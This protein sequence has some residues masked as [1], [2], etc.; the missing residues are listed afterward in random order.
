LPIR[1]TEPARGP[2]AYLQYLAA[3]P[4][5]CDICGPLDF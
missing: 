1:G 4:I 3:A 5:L 2:S